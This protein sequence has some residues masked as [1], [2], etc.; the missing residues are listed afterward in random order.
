[1]TRLSLINKSDEN[2][3]FIQVALLFRR[4]ETLCFREFTLFQI[5]TTMMAIAVAA[6]C[7]KRSGDGQSSWCWETMAAVKLWQNYNQWNLG[8]KWSSL[9]QP[10]SKPKTKWRT[11]KKW[12]L[13]WVI[14]DAGPI[15]QSPS[16]MSLNSPSLDSEPPQPPPTLDSVLGKLGNPGKYQVRGELL[17]N[18]PWCNDFSRWSWC[19]SLRPTIS[20]WW[21]ITSSWLSTRQRFLFIARWVARKNDLDDKH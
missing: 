8:S 13:C 11:Y 21:S 10:S 4:S 19:C 12:S 7:W 1:M 3:V 2:Q 15:F 18:C 9:D 17:F 6:V 20:L 14:V 16:K 5:S